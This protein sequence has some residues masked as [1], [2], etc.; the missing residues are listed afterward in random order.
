M[1]DSPYIA[2]LLRYLPQ[3]GPDAWHQVALNWN[4]GNDAAPLW[5]IIQQPTCDR[6]TA[7]LLYWRG[8]PT[9]MTQYAT[10]DAVPYWDLASY[11]LLQAIE[12]RYLAGG[13]TR[14]EIAYDPH[15]DDTDLTADYSHSSIVRPIPAAMA[16]ATGGQIAPNWAWDDGFPP[17]VRAEGDAVMDAREQE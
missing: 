15:T 6:G 9:W 1:G 5:W 7:L 17:D 10:R 2:A 13:Y 11:D 12:T 16:V 14:Q 3:C 8:A 4:W